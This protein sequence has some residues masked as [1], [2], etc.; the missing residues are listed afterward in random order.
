MELP[1][2]YKLQFKNLLQEMEAETGELFQITID[3]FNDIKANYV[4]GDFTTRNCKLE[5]YEIL[6]EYN[7][8]IGTYDS[9]EEFSSLLKKLRCKE[10]FS[11]TKLYDAP[12]GKIWLIGKCKK[13][14]SYHNNVDGRAPNVV[15]VTVCQNCHHTLYSKWDKVRLSNNCDS[16]YIPNGRCGTFTL[17]DNIGKYRF[18]NN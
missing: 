17:I 18:V 7:E 8:L 4:L 3:K 12:N 1:E 14:N 5:I 2:K 13:C 9:R 11:E 16:I 6:P 10:L 15:D